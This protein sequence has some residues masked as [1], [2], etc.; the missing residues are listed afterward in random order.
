M[1][2]FRLPIE[3]ANKWIAALKSGSFKQGSGRLFSVNTYC[4][5]GVAGHICGVP[6]EMMDDKGLFSKQH[7]VISKEW[8]EVNKIFAIAELIGDSSNSFVKILM[9]MNDGVCLKII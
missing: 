7:F 1:K 4:C 6:D 8:E 3:F 2:T 9:N 5:I